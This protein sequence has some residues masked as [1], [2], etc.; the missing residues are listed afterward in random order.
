MSSLESLNFEQSMEIIKILLEEKKCL[1]L[2]FKGSSMLP[3]IKPGSR[4]I[5]NKFNNLSVGKIYV[6]IDRD[7]DSFSK[8]V[9]HRLYEIN[10]YQYYFKGDNRNII[11][12]FVEVKDIIGEVVSWN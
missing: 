9:C 2:T 12:N 1:E 5:I 4:L 8:I 6:Y 11:D 3:T 7:L 10:K